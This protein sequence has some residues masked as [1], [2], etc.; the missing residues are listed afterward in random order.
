VIAGF[1]FLGWKERKSSL[2]HSAEIASEKS[3]EER[4]IA[5]GDKT[6]NERNGVNTAVREI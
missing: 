4:E 5:K 1:V 2:P 6:G 3:S